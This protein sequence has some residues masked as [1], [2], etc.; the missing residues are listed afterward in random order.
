MNVLLGV[1]FDPVPSMFEPPDAAEF[2]QA[3]G[4]ACPAWGRLEGNF[5]NIP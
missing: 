1:N 2:Y 5:N 3:L 4:V